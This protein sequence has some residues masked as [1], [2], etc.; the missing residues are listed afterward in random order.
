MGVFSPDVCIDYQEMDRAKYQPSRRVPMGGKQ[1][2]L[3]DA[4][5]GAGL[6]CFV[7]ISVLLLQ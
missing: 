6:E 7:L 1:P 4:P 3:L 5:C 2:S